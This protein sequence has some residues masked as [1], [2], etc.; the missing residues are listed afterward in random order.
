MEGLQDFQGRLQEVYPV[1]ESY[2]H[3]YQKTAG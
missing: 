2:D 1:R 3:K